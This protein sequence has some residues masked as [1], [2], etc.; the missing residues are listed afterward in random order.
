ML[1]F[2]TSVPGDKVIGLQANLWSECIPDM[3]K[4]EF[5]LVPRIC[6]LAEAAWLPREQRPGEAHLGERIRRHYAWFDALQINFRQEDGTPRL[7]PD[8]RK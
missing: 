6:A 8:A 4:L 1:N 2:D 5:M 3:R 7:F